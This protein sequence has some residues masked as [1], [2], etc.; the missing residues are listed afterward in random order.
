MDR[1]LR[2]FGL[3]D[4]L[5]RHRSAVT[6]QVLAEEHQV[7]VRTVYRDIQMLQALGAPIGGEAGL[8]YVLLPGFFLPPLMFSLEELEALVL[9]A[10]WVEQLPDSALAS[11]ATNALAK[12]GTAIPEELAGRIDDTG[13]WPVMEGG[14]GPSQLLGLVRRAMREERGLSIRYQNQEGVVSE[15]VVLP[16]QLAYFQSRQ[17]FAAWCFKRNAFARFRLDRV[18]HA[19]LSEQRFHRPRVELAQQ[20][21]EEFEVQLE[22][23]PDDKDIP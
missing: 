22:Q 16:V 15:R 20:W 19:E 18:Q 12:L 6:A 10:R 4:S 2:L 13:L 11:S 3:M 7:S 1:I 8:G 14:A 23:G 17:V 9:G 21:F 5:R